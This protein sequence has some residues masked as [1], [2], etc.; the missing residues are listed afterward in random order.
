[1]AGRRKAAEPAEALETTA[2]V[3]EAYLRLV[4]QNVAT[5]HDRAQ[6]F[7]VAA[8]VMRRVLVDDA[9]KRRAQKRGGE[10]RKVRLEDLGDVSFGERPD[11]ILALE[12]CL[13]ELESLDADKARLVELRFFAGLSLE[14]TAELLETSRATVVRQWRM[15]KGW[16]HRRLA[17]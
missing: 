1:V 9:R 3:H 12:T 5:W 4:D 8:R 14:Q 2:L 10:V 13:A 6:F 17:A 16:L 7:A 15:T 11:S